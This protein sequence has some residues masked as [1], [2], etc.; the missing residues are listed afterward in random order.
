MQLIRRGD[1]GPAVAE[2]R[3]I[4]VMLGLLARAVTRPRRP[5]QRP[6]R[7]RVRTRGAGVPAEPRPHRRRHRRRRD[8]AGARRVPLAARRPR[9]DPLGARAAGR[10]RRPCPAG[11]AAGDGLRRRPRRRHLRSAH[12]AGGARRSSARCGLIRTAP[13]ARRPCTRCAGSAARS[14]A[15]ARRWLREAATICHAGPNL[16]GKRI[17]ID[18]GHGGADPGL[19]VRDG[20]LRWTEADLGVR[21]RGPAGGPARGGRHAVH[22][23]RGPDTDASQRR[24]GGARQRLGADLLI[25]CTSTATTT[26]RRRAWPR[27]TTAPGPA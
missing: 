15:A 14:S 26:R 27:T 9:P 7:R 1:T 2:I 11:A 18:P 21:P 22:L 10:R 25:R 4:L 23:T 24:A 5:R 13:A 19:V 8:L 6:V 20:R 3:A 17:V 16:V 12:R